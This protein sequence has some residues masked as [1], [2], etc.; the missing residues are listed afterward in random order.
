M[1]ILPLEKG[2]FTTIYADPPWPEIGG[3]VIKRGA[4]KHYNLMSVDEIK[5]MGTEI[6]RVTQDNSH[7]YLWA[8]N[9]YL[10]HALHV[11]ES[12]GYMYKT[13]ITWAKDRIGL[14]QYFRGQTEHCLFGVRGNIPYR[15]K[16]DGLRAQGTTLIIAPRTEHSVKPE[17]MREYIELV[18]PGP[19]LELFSRVESPNWAS[20]GNQII[21]K[22]LL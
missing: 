17:K 18:S 8:T 14:G 21:T 10:H 5:L 12:W 13:T 22:R 1:P 15:V 20:F 16:P 11:M 7:C 6:K 19:Y 9:N 4:D 2:N 3:G